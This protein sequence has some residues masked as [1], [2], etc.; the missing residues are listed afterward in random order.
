MLDVLDTIAMIVCLLSLVVMVVGLVLVCI[1]KRRKKGLKTL[2]IGVLLFLGSAIVGASVHKDKPEQ[3]AHNNKISTSSSTSS[4][5][6]VT[7]NES[8]TQ[9]PAENTDKKITSIQDNKSNENDGLGFE[10]WALLI[11]FTFFA[12]STLYHYWQYKRKKRFEE[13]VSMLQPHIP[14]SNFS[15]ACE[16]FQELNAYENNYRLARDEKLLE[17]QKYVT[18]ISSKKTKPFGRLLVT[19]QAIVFESPEKNERIT[20][21]RIASVNITY[22]G[23]QINRRSG[24]P[25]NY[26][27]TATP[28]F[29]AIVRSLAQP[30]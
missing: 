20:W 30:Y 11:F 24:V 23:C 6:V 14:P 13:Q 2:G 26:E 7:Q 19:N 18:F 1:K 16:I 4:I 3:V 17:I 29:A 27:F 15:E 12:C 9:T 8:V 5:D 25:W 28:R 22:Q 10:E 21:T